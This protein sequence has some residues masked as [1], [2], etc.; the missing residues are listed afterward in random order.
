MPSAFNHEVLRLYPLFLHTLPEHKPRPLI[1]LS[2]IRSDIRGLSGTLRLAHLCVTL[3]YPTAFLFPGPIV[4]I[5]LLSSLRNILQILLLPL[6]E[7]LI[8][9]F[10]LLCIHRFLKYR[11]IQ[12]HQILFRTARRIA[13]PLQILRVSIHL[14]MQRHRHSHLILQYR[15]LRQPPAY[16]VPTSSYAPLQHHQP[17]LILLR[18]NQLLNFLRSH[19]LIRFFTL[20]S[21]LFT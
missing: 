13:H 14:Q 16:Q 9:L 20:H 5:R 2:D 1:R 19:R 8:L 4:L 3:L 17:D 7:V 18:Q 10:A 21:Y 15:S 12:I 11:I 6:F